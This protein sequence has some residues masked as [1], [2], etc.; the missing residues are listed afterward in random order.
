ML[1]IRLNNRL[2]VLAL[3]AAA[4]ILAVAAV[5]GSR[6]QA[7]AAK[8]PQSLIVEIAQDMTTAHIGEGPFHEDGMPDGGNTFIVEGFI[9]LEGTLNGSNG[10]L[11]SED[12]DGNLVTEPEF[13]DQ[14][15]GR[16]ICRGWFLGDG[17]Y[18]QGEPWAISTQHFELGGQFGEVTLVSEGYELPDGMEE[19]LYRSITGGTGP[20]FGA[21]G[22]QIQH[23]M[24]LN[25]TQGTNFHIEFKLEKK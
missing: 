7:D 5:I 19:T 4:M 1:T 9:Y 23:F 2:T 25:V 24:G 12:A 3:A 8:P 11:I 21:S 13:P 18:A 20:Y 10:I 17:M 15:I 16:W 22:Q 14:V 6:N